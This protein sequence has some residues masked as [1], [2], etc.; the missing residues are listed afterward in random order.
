[1]KEIFITEIRERDRIE[2]IFL[3]NKKEMPIS[4]GGKPYLNLK[5]MD[6]TGEIEGRVWENAREIA[7][8]FERDDF[9]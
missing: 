7:G 1:M 6:R 9:V 2:E 3:V 5:I 4:K 8:G